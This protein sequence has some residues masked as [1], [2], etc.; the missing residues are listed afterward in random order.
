MTDPAAKWTHAGLA[1]AAP[2][3]QRAV[4]Q[5]SV[6][7]GVGIVFEVKVEVVVLEVRMRVVV[8][9]VVVLAGQMFNVALVV[10]VVEVADG[11]ALNS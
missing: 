10:I 11:A 6:V 2:K 4:V 3:V 5:G 8:V 7:G 9:V 1:S